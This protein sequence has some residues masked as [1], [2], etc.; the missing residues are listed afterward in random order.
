MDETK[1]LFWVIAFAIAYAWPIICF[2]GLLICGF[3]A[4][5]VGGKQSG[6]LCFFLGFCFGPIGIVIAAIMGNRAPEKKATVSSSLSSSKSSSGSALSDPFGASARKMMAKC[7]PRT[8]VILKN[9]SAAPAAAIPVEQTVPCPTCN[10]P[11]LVN[12]L[13]RGQV[14]S[15]PHCATKF[16]T[17]A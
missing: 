4:R 5:A 9:A 3:I 13:Q 6:C 8:R 10:K 1:P 11:I 7:K 2:F 17:D 15:C 16:S 14:Y 12:G